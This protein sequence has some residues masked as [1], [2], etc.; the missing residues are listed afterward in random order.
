VG[1][2][3]PLLELGVL[4]LQLPQSPG[5]RHFHPA[6]L[7]RHLE[8]C[9]TDVSVAAQRLDRHAG[10]R[11]LQDNDNLFFDEFALFQ[12]HHSPGFDGLFCF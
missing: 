3:E 1:F 12:V 4:A 10:L 2:G 9:F 6:V 8:G 5:V 11:P 7:A